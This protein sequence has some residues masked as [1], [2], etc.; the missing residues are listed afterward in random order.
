MPSF[1]WLGSLLGGVGGYLGS[2]G[3]DTS[4]STTGVAPEFSGLANSVAQRGQEI[5]NMPYNP[6]GYNRVSDFTPYQFAGMD[7]AADRAAN[8]T[9]PA[10]AQNALSGMFASNGGY[11]GGPSFN[12]YMG[13][14]ASSGANRWEGRTTDVGT[15]PYAGSNPFLENSIQNTMG[16][17]A[18]TYNQSVAPTMAATAYKSGSFGNTGQSEMETASRDQLQR[19]LGRV[20]GDMR[21]QDYGMQ[22]GLA[23]AGLNRSVGTQLADYG[24]NAGLAEGGLNRSMQ[25]Q[26]ADLSR[27]AGLYESAMNRDQNSYDSAMG[28]MMSGLGMAGNIN[29]LGYDASNRMMGIG[30]QMQGQG[31]NVL[32]SQYD[33]FQQAQNWPFRTYDAMMAPFSTRAVGSSTTGSSAAGNPW[34]GAMGGAMLGNNIWGQMFP[35]QAQP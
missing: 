11:G 4:T 16:D 5:G 28:R 15:N 35:Q 9:L 26:L 21:M 19:N 31:Q 23:E 6:Y 30:A 8:N 3:Q 7:M 24:R 12:P 14:T 1:D 18:Q 2:K 29:S 32:N 27:N 20:S 25:G 10:E 17:M 22:Q 33:D 34:A 13:Q